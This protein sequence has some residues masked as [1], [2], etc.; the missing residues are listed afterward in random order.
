VA[1]SWEVL[2]EVAHYEMREYDVR[3]REKKEHTGTHTPSL[4][5]KLWLSLLCRTFCCPSSEFWGNAPCRMLGGCRTFQ[6]TSQVSS[7]PPLKLNICRNFGKIC[8]TRRGGRISESV[9]YLRCLLSYPKCMS[10]RGPY[11]GLSKG[12][13]W[14][15]DISQLVFNE[16]QIQYLSKNLARI[17]WQDF[18]SHKSTTLI[19]ILGECILL[20]M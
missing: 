8:H 12:H 9:S 17:L 16:S 1:G 6:K 19:F 2:C 10:S 20:R 5:Y 15:D 11:T 7:L 14:T 18:F 13:G 4:W 3:L